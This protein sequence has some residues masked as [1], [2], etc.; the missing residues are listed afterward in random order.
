[1]TP[2]TIPQAALHPRAAS[3]MVLAPDSASAKPMLTVLVTCE[4]DFSIQAS[5]SILD[6][7]TKLHRYLHVS[8][9][10]ISQLSQ[11]GEG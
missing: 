9:L 2:S 1:M 10:S 4:Y 8:F 3:I 7:Q 5:P 6:A 11:V